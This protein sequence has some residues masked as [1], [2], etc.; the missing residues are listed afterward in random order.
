MERGRNQ[1]L[2]RKSVGDK[3]NVKQ[4]LSF[5]RIFFFFSFAGTLCRGMRCLL[6]QEDRNSL[7]NIC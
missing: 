4:Y 7:D 6:C 1:F 2:D 3:L 5:R